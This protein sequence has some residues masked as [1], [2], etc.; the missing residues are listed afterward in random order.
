MTTKNEYIASIMLEAAD[1]LQM[2]ESAGANGAGERFYKEKVKTIQNKINSL[3]K[4]ADAYERAGYEDKAPVKK[5]LD[6]LKNELEKYKENMR[7]FQKTSRSSIIHPRDR[8]HINRNLAK[9]SKNGG[10]NV[11]YT[12]IDWGGDTHNDPKGYFQ[13][14]H[15]NDKLREEKAKKNARINKRAA[16]KEAIDLLYDKAMECNTLDEATEYIDKAE[17]LELL[18]DE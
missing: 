15:K 4:K 13:A 5:E 2:D 9:L 1:L 3:K 17:Q 8:I 10:A 7:N 16:I 14:Y 18:I 12:D 6:K 11:A